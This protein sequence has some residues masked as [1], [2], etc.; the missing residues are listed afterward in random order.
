MRKLT[1]EEFIQMA[2][3]LHGDK[4]TYDKVNYVKSSTKVIISCLTCCEDF[5][6]TPNNHLNG[7][8]CSKC[9]YRTNGEKSKKTVE[10]F[11][12]DAIKIH[13]DKYGYQNVVYVDAH[14]HIQI[15]CLAC[16]KDFLQSPTSHIS[17]SGCRDCGNKVKSKKMRKTLNKF[18]EDA[19]KVHGIKYG[20]DKVVYVDANTLVKI[21]CIKCEKDFSQTPENHLHGGCLTCGVRINGEIKKKKAADTFITRAIKV[22]GK[23]YGYDKTV[24]IC[25]RTNVLITCL[26]CNEEFP[27][28]PGHHLQGQGCT[29]C[30]Y[31]L[32]GENRRNTAAAEFVCKAVKVH[33]DKY[34]YENV[35]YVDAN[36]PVKITC[37]KCK[38]DFLQTP[39]NH[40]NGSGCSTCVNK[41][42]GIVASKLEE[43]FEPLGFKV[44]HMGNFVSK[45]IGKMDI[46][47]TKEDSII[48]VEVDGFQHFR[49]VK[50][51][52][53]KAIDV[54]KRDL[55]KHMCAI[56]MGH[57]VIR[58]D[59]EWVWNSTIK[60]KTE[61][62]SRLYHAIVKPEPSI[63]EIFLSDKPDK[64]HDHLCYIQCQF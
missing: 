59:Q 38:R 60:N 32:N 8:G 27:Q 28:T 55:K 46:R 5:E 37:L 21:T 50:Y 20:Y 22:H 34:G 16:D 11:I 44:E 64:Y 15:T 29:T 43:I 17:G 1:T 51:Q 47:I 39:D 31:R 7:Q 9:R 56:E 45:G 25:A 36:T 48:F 4:Y 40:F 30:A 12:K 62:A 54:Q 13:G 6:Q 2:I 19:I 61:W 58:I 53:S 23:K 57:K 24:Y 18:I 33:S 14:T 10:E 52:K 3:K 26:V 35:V 41:T 49:D 63:D 42:E